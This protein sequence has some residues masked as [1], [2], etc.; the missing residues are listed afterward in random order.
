MPLLPCDKLVKHVLGM[1]DRLVFAEFTAYRAVAIEMPTE[2]CPSQLFSLGA[3][4][5]RIRGFLNDMR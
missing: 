1:D 5:Q 2:M 4:T 3:V